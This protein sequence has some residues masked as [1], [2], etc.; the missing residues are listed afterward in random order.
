MKRLERTAAATAIQLADAEKG[1]W[2]LTID[3][4][5]LAIRNL[6]RRCGILD[7]FPDLDGGDFISAVGPMLDT[8]IASR[9][10]MATEG[11]P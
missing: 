7:P 5:A 6:L 1:R 4:R 8:C 2:H 10:Q 9:R 11:K 3:E